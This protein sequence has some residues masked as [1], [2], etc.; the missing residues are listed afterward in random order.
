[1]RSRWFRGLAVAW[2]RGP[3]TRKPRDR[4]TARRRIFVLIPLIAIPLLRIVSTYIVFSQT[5]DEP[6]HIA[7]GFQWLTTSEYDLDQEHPPL[8][9]IAFA[10]YAVAS[11]AKP[12][13][14]EAQSIGNDLLEHNDRY[15]RNLFG[16]RA[17]NLPFFLLGLIV[18]GLWTKHL[19]GDTAALVA[20]ALF[21]ALPPILGHAGLA[22]T[23]MAAAATTTAALYLFD[24]WLETPSWK[25]AMLAAAAIG[26]G[27]LAKYSFVVFFP[28]GAIVLLFA[29]RRFRVAHVAVMLL[30]AF[31]IVWSGYKFST[32]SL[33]DARLRAFASG[34]TPAGAADY[35]KSV[36]YE[37]LP[38]DLLEG[39]YRNVD[40]A[41]KRGVHGIDFVDWAKA[42]G[43]QFPE[44]DQQAPPASTVRDRFLQPFRA[45]WQ[46]ISVYRWIPAPDF[47]VGLEI[48]W[49]HSSK[50]HRAFLFGQFSD[51][52]WWYYFPVL[53]FFKTPLAFV[54]LMIAGMVLMIRT[55]RAEAIGVALAPIA[56]LLPALPSGINIG[57]RHILPLY[58]LLTI[59]A[60]FAV[61]SLWS[62]FRLVM[63]ILLAW[64]F[65]ASAFAH[66]DYMT[67]FN[68]AAGRHPERIAVDSN[69]DWGQDIL[70][71]AKAVQREHIGHLHLAC[72]GTANWRMLVPEAEE[73]PPFTRVHGWV[74][75]SEN[76]LAFGLKKQRD[77]FAWLRA[78]EPVR[79]VGTSIRLYRIP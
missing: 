11:G 17:S 48:V 40:D 45:V 41:T 62:R 77:A 15:R 75:V 21:G 19:F 60:A 50:G 69:L 70:R 1:M 58:P 31:V 6:F 5:N 68:E 49:R 65:I 76:S 38:L 43:Y 36:G 25:R 10:A 51:H 32:G 47:F 78:Y 42:A 24:R 46:R 30:V 22:T 26:A 34:M 71:L 63:A 33:I 23:D 61:V 64:Y 29:R 55:R 52:G 16:A 4:A 28:M 39:Y 20:M 44:A 56:M 72:F 37:W 8:A 73:L 67:Y 3:T 74:A 79:R 9:R 27:L 18:V 54:V 57:V 59:A 7:S 66:P 2:S 14:G 13:A 12:K 53:L 35:A